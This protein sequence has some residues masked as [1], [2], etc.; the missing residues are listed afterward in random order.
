MM[1]R[2]RSGMLGMLAALLV[3]GSAWACAP[4]AAPPTP[5]PTK[6]VTALAAQ[7]TAPVSQ[8]TAAPATPTAAPA[9]PTLAPAAKVETVR[10]GEL[11]YMADMPF[12]IA[13]EKGYFQEQGI[14]AKFERFRSAADMVAPLSTGELQVGGGT[15]GA[16]L[17]NALARGVEIKAIANRSRP[18]IPVDENWWMV[19]SDLKDQVK[20]FTD[21]K[22]RT[23]NMLSPANIAYYTLGLT[24]P[25]YGL[26]LKD[27]ELEHLAPPETAGAFEKKSIDISLVVEPNVLLFEAKGI[28]MKLA[29]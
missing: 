8:P 1:L 14:D 10:I 13:L 20:G 21:F 7:P 25:K 16:G 22:G 12:Y 11:G 18:Q 29:Q 27:L 28:A 6:G 24:L 23:V 3:A 4:Q 19:R 15:A 26:T 2:G 9:K 17:F 5:S